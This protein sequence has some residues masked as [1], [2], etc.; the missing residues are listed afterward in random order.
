DVDRIVVREEV[1]R[2]N[3]DLNLILKLIGAK[4]SKQ[5]AVF[6]NYGYRGLYGGL[7]EN[8]IHHRKGLKPHQ[9]ILDHMGFEELAANMYR[10]SLTQQYLKKYPTDTV[11]LACLLH[12]KMGERVRQDHVD[13]GL[14]LPEDMPAVET[15]KEAYRRLKA[16]ETEKERVK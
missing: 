12:K 9:A 4:F 7:A 8:Q 6:H 16:L 2:N 3:H 10:T 13:L 14:D 15:I 1:K 11:L 5:W